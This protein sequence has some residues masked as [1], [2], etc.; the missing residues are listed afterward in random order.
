MSEF[1]RQIAQMVAASKLP[2]IPSNNAGQRYIGKAME[3]KTGTLQRPAEEF[4]KGIGDILQKYAEWHLPQNV[5]NRALMAYKFLSD[6]TK[7]TPEQRKKIISYPTVQETLKEYQKVA[8]E[9]FYT[10]DQGFVNVMPVQQSPEQAETEA[11]AKYY[12]NLSKKTEELLPFEKKEA[13]LNLDMKDLEK[14]IT[15]ATTPEQIQAAQLKV[16]Q[17]KEN[18]TRSQQARKH[19]AEAFPLEQQIRQERIGNLQVQK[20]E[21]AVRTNLIQ[22]QI[23]TEKETRPLDVD[24]LKQ[25]KIL[26]EKQ[27]NM[28]QEKVN[29]LVHAASA[30]EDKGQWEEYKELFKTRL[31]QD[32]ALRKKYLYVAQFDPT[33]YALEDTMTTSA[34]VDG[35]GLVA[36]PVAKDPNG[37]I[38][39]AR[40]S[41][42]LTS[43][44]AQFWV[45]KSLSELYN[46]FLSELPNGNVNKLKGIAQS[47]Q[48]LWSKTYG[49]YSPEVA[50]NAP[51]LKP[52]AYDDMANLWK[53]MALKLDEQLPSDDPSKL[54][55]VLK[56]RYEK[57]VGGK[58]PIPP[59]FV[60]VEGGG[61]LK[62]LQGLGN[63]IL[64]E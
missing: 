63:W 5:H 24:L 56:K 23:K 26:L 46:A 55:P 49:H 27:A 1:T 35:M 37:R 13:A 34:M 22:E 14:Q 61:P 20:N 42:S 21:N 39:T 11:R 6:P 7:L 50:S 58:T 48:D 47:F 60:P 59:G 16:Q 54:D 3:A 41:A 38:L 43:P 10:D 52:D 25:K 19:E 62:W 15:E 8:P 36:V 29:T 17:L 31:E 45:N 32:K 51:Q 64:G 2:V 9:Y 4:G 18:L 12:E 57:D 44:T 33:S 53:Y 30:K 28:A 40:V